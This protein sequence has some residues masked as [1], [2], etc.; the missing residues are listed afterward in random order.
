MRSCK[1]L[2]VVQ[3]NQIALQF[4]LNTI[5]SPTLPP[6]WAILGFLAGIVM[7]LSQLIISNIWYH[8]GITHY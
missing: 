6:T 8:T 1:Q 3:I 5:P 2:C 7:V 4:N